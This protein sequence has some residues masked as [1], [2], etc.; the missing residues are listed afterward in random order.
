M[1][2]QFKYYSL[3]FSGPSGSENYPA[4]RK[5]KA[6]RLCAVHDYGM[7]GG[8]LYLLVRSV[9]PLQDIERI[10]RKHALPARVSPISGAH[11]TI[12]DRT[13]AQEFTRGLL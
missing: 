1:K 12:R 7:V 4:E 3:D 11:I 2:K 13:V 6:A 5:L 8:D 9:R 10:V